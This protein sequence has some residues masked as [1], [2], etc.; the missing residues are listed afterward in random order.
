MII[1]STVLFILNTLSRYLKSLIDPKKD[2]LLH[3]LWIKTASPDN[4]NQI[5]YNKE[6]VIK[7]N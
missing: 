5:G 3:S 6:N 7:I 2:S 1:T 4:N